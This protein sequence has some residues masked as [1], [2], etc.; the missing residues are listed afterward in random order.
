M[1][2][3]ITAQRVKNKTR[4]STMPMIIPLGLLVEETAVSFFFFFV[5]ITAKKETTMN[6]VI[7]IYHIYTG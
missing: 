6:P 1:H 7:M 3:P 4:D 2:H 5:G